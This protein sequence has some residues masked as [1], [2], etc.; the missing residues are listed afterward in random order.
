[1]I[2]ECDKKSHDDVDDAVNSAAKN[3][4]EQKEEDKM[5]Q[6]LYDNI[7]YYQSH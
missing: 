4:D 1:M 2:C 7:G 6:Y 5:Q 3:S